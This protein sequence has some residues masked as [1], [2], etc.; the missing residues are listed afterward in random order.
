MARRVQEGQDGA[1]VGRHLIGADMLRDAAGFARNDGGLA[2]RVQQRGLAVVDMAHDR[3]DR[4]ARLH[5][6]VTID[7]RGDDLLHIAVAD[8]QDLVAEFLDHQLGGVGVDGLVGSDHH[9]HLHQRLDHVGGAFGHA[10]G[11]LLD[12]DGLGQA[13]FAELL[14]GT[15]GLAHRLLAGAFL[16]ALHRGHAALAAAF[17]VQRLVQ[18]QL[19]AATVVVGGLGLGGLVAV[20]ALDAVG[21]A[22]HAG[23]DALGLGARGGSL[24]RGLIGG[25]G[26]GRTGRGLGTLLARLCLAA[27]LVGGILRGLGLGQGFGLEG[28][29]ALALLAGLGLD[30]GAAALALLLPGLLVGQALGGVIGLACLGGGKGLQAAFHLGIGDACGALGAVAGHAGG[31]RVL[32]FLRIRHRRGCLGHHDALALGFDDDAFGATVAE[33]LLDCAGAITAT[34]AQG[35]FS[36]F[37]AHLR[38]HSFPTAVLPSSC[39][40]RPVSLPASKITLSVRPPFA[41]APCM[42]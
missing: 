1:T 38:L 36:V 31:Q 41:S 14:F 34:K 21:L 19:A 5:V 11:Q 37:V 29:L 6:L 25:G 39:P 24:D 13:D 2:D 33:A 26:L 32:F 22:G 42:T 16:L 12:H 28:L 8:A 9:A 27:G 17:A 18:R 23:R 4:R 10:V 35:G 40:R 30:L 15:G 3:D 7:R 20:R